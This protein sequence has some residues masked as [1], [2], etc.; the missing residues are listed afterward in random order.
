M[1]FISFDVDS[2]FCFDLFGVVTASFDFFV[3]VFPFSD[4][5]AT[6]SA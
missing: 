2:I 5:I 1:L 6:H 4:G 3:F